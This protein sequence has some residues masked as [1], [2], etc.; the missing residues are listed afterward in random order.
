M[1]TPRLTTQRF[2][3]RAF[4]PA[5]LVAFTQYRAAPEVARYQSWT[6]YQYED[7]QVLFEGTDYADFARPGQWYQ[8][9]IAEK[10]QGRLLGDLAVHFIDEQQVE[11]GFT[12]APAHQG[13]GVASEALATLLQYLFETLRRHRVVATTDA[14]N[15]AS[16]RLLERLGFRREAHFVQNVFFKGAWGDE[17]QYALLASEYRARNAG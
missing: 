15:E 13:Q 14:R 12:V 17:F 10:G 7:A 6:D 4:E 1:I 3:L 16:W 2:T 5:D 11:V 8:L 9:A